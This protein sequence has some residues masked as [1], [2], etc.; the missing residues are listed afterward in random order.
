[1][2]ASYQQGTGT[3]VS[4]GLT[5]DPLQGEP[6]V[7]RLLLPGAITGEPLSTISGAPLSTKGMADLVRATNGPVLVA[8]F[9]GDGPGASQAQ[10]A[11]AAALSLAARLP[12]TGSVA[13]SP[14]T[15]CNS[16]TSADCGAGSSALAVST[17][18]YRAAQRFDAMPLAARRVW[19]AQHLSALRA[20]QITLGQLP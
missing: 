16:Q 4:S 14:R 15:A 17:A 5:G 7:F 18:E 13:Q 2:A 10:R 20:G 19:L 8:S 11:V 6:P 12:V 1:V 9:V 3:D